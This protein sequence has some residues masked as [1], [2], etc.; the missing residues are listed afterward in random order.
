MII[1]IS[2]KAGSGKGSVSKIIAEKLWYERISIGNL[3][4]QLADEMWLSISEFN[5]LGEQPDKATEFDLKY[6]DYQ[7]NFDLQNNIILDS[8]LWFFCQPKS[9]KVFLEVS[10]EEAAKRI[11]RDDRTTDNFS[12]VEQAYITTQ[13]RNKADRERYLNLYGIDLAD[14]NNFDLVID[15]TLQTPQQTA[16]NILKQFEIF[17]KKQK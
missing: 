15:T 13:E 6:E 14:H 9:F 3:K 12:S 2:G 17:Q 1:T 4:R 11:M 5:M 10:P 8:R 7:K 16:E